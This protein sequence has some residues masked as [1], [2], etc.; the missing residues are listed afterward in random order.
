MSALLSD[1]PRAATQIAT[2]IS[3]VANKDWPLLVGKDVSEI[4][5]GLPCVVL[6]SPI[7][8]RSELFCLVTLLSVLAAGV[9]GGATALESRSLVAKRAWGRFAVCLFFL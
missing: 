4:K 8:F 9:Q 6:G 3:F 5:V 2:L 7:F 1:T